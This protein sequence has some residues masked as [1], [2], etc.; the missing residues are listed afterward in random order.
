MQTRLVYD[1]GLSKY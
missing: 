1:I